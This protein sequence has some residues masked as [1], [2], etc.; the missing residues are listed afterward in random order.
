LTNRSDS[1]DIVDNIERF[2]K[3]CTVLMVQQQVCI[4]HACSSLGFQTLSSTWL[5]KAFDNVEELECSEVKELAK[6]IL[7]IIPVIKKDVRF[8]RDTPG[9]L[10]RL[11]LYEGGSLVLAKGGQERPRLLVHFA[12][13]A[14]QKGLQKSAMTMLQE[15]TEMYDSP[16]R[17]SYYE[18][19]LHA[20]DARIIIQVEQDDLTG[21]V[22][23]MHR[24]VDVVAKWIG[25]TSFELAT[26]LYRLGCFCK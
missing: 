6:A 10:D 3:R 9:S 21:A 18:E 11:S 16:T 7:R 12:L 15:T 2:L 22:R 25:N 13:T 23:E 26:D 24:R 17:P 5:L 8:D 20:I 14:L 4:S 1:K 19:L